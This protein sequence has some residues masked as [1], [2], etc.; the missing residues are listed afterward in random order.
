MVR[1]DLR[2]SRERTQILIY[3]ALY[4]SAEKMTL[5]GE[6]GRMRT[7]ARRVQRQPWTCTSRLS[8]GDEEVQLQSV[9]AESTEKDVQH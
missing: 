6:S 9:K 5:E 7:V 4:P 3:I 1:V 2:V 8:A